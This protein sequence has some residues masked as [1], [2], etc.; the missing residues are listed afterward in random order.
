MRAKHGRP[1]IAGRKRKTAEEEEHSVQKVARFKVF[2]YLSVV[3]RNPPNFLSRKWAE[4]FSRNFQD[5]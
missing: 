3:I 5:L 4:I 2:M 1:G